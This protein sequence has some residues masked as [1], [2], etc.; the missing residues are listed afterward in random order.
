MSLVTSD[1]FTNATGTILHSVID[2]SDVL[3]AW[4][5]V[6]Y[7]Q[8]YIKLQFVVQRVE[9][10]NCSFS[11]ETFN[12]FFFFFSFL[13]LMQSVSSV[14]L[15]SVISEACLAFSYTAC[16]IPSKVWREWELNCNCL[17]INTND[18]TSPRIK[19]LSISQKAGR[20]GRV[21]NRLHRGLYMK[22]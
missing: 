16:I 5:I 10:P 3:I 15:T 12:L 18:E 13:H 22:F 20:G 1:S 17:L 8:I 9:G 14:G 11:A 19:P 6:V 2:G 4:P 7:I 21:Q